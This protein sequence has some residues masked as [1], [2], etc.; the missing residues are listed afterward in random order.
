MLETKQSGE[1]GNPAR[2]L[3][4]IELFAGIGG[5]ADGFREHGGFEIVAMVDI[6][7]DCRDTYLENHPGTRY[8]IKDVSS[9]TG[10]EL[11]RLADGREIDG[12]VG[13]PPCQ[14]FSA[15][16]KRDPN[17]PMNGLAGHYFR[18][19]K[20]IR[21]RFVVMENVPRILDNASFRSLMREVEGCGYVLWAG[22]LNAALYGV[23]QTRQRAIVI[24]LQEAL[25][26]EP[27]PPKATHF[28]E[29]DVFE[30]ASQRLESLRGQR[31]AHA[32]G[33][34]PAAERI[35]RKGLGKVPW[36]EY[37]ESD[38]EEL[39][40]LTPIVRV[41]EALQGLPKPA[42]SAEKPPVNG[43]V[44]WHHT[45]EMLKRLKDVPPGGN[46]NGGRPGERY[47]SQAYS[48][49][50]PE[51]LA[52]TLSTYF[53]NPGSGRF[54]H[55][56]ELRCLSVREA[57]RIQTISDKGDQPDAFFFPKSNT[58]NERLVGNAFPRRLARAIAG[59]IHASLAA[60][61]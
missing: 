49:L 33:L 61:Q 7:E 8:L 55:H 39:T 20:E 14:G 1:S 30:Y 35:R 34:C 27:T 19:V 11:R 41:G 10:D 37:M 45:P 54:L 5:V 38:Y 44:R 36:L 46:L 60:A 16:G 22:I 6:D 17:H 48:R 26:I 52:F 42:Q 50:H 43:H 12:I 29:R 23:P 18:L 32:L 51:G 15:A 47:F 59:A 25:G 21:P 2:R 31:G 28:G 3:G 40:K 4:I 13:C 24:A 53:H 56:E 58:V 57:A 9:L